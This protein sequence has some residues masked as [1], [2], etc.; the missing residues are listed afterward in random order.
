V[1]D[2]ETD[3]LLA[4]VRGFGDADVRRPSLLPGWTRGH[5]LTHLARSGD[6]LRGLAEGIVSGVPA[7]G[8]AGDDARTRDSASLPGRS[9]HR[10]GRSS[11]SITGRQVVLLHRN[12]SAS[13]SSGSIARSWSIAR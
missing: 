12:S 4:T 3:R 7:A 11:A 6:V 13:S 5:L 9:S 1:L 10:C 8:H 2:Q